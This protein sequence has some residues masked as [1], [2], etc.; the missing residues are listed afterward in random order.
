MNFYE[1]EINF[2]II[3]AALKQLSH[4]IWVDASWVGAG[5]GIA[6][7]QFCNLRQLLHE[8]FLIDDSAFI[9]FDAGRNI[10]ILVH[11]ASDS[12]GIFCL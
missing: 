1:L 4:L 5:A 7:C 6:Y 12:R 11:L 2:L 3:V 9:V 10:Q 8:F